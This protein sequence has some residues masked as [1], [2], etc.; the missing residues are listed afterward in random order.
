MADRIKLWESLKSRAYQQDMMKF[1]PVSH[2]NTN[3]TSH[4]GKKS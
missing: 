1:I 4:I 3:I 2:S